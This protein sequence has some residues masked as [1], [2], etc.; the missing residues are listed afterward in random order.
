M[1]LNIF[2]SSLL[3]IFS[4]SAC[5][6]NGLTPLQTYAVA[7]SEFTDTVRKYNEYYEQL[8]E[9]TQAEW[10]S[11]YRPIIRDA[12]RALDAW[13]LSVYLESADI[14]TKKELYMAVKAELLKLLAEVLIEED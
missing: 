11:K 8:D 5:A 14:E 6:I 12:D 4:I 3:L 2:L 1:K 7:S 10:N 13:K 9:E